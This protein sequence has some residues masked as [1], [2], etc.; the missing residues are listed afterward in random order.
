MSKA[1][2]RTTDDAATDE[3]DAEATRVI[4]ED[5]GDAEDANQTQ[6]L[7]SPSEDIDNDIYRPR[8]EESADPTRVIS[9]EPIGEQATPD[10]P[11][12]DDPFGDQALREADERR[13]EEAAE[14]ARERA[15]R[16]RALGTVTPSQEPD[17]VVAE[18]PGPSTDK[19][20]PSLGLFLFRLVAAAVLGVHGFQHLT[21]RQGTLAMIEKIGLPYA[22]ELV[23][24]LG[25]CECLAALAL[26]FGLW[27][28]I[29]GVGV[30][31]LGVLALAFVHW[32]SFN[33]FQNVGIAGEPA[34]LLAG[35]GILLL[36]VGAGG[37]ALDARTRHRRRA[38]RAAAL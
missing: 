12:A 20:W 6:V 34:L 2:K 1:V 37:W 26:L 17:P 28:R 31:A 18:A 35:C 22:V 10:E 32:G 19:W 15:E 16:E 3:A 36:C 25:I 21:Q 9:E 4:A 27:T 14:R 29:A 38:R 30:L 33:I 13:R 23:W 24:V 8:A 7:G 5:A 11:G